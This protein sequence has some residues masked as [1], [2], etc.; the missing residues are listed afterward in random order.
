MTK[1][2]LAVL[3]SLFLILSMVGCGSGNTDSD[4]VVEND[5]EEPIDEEQQKEEDESGEVADAGEVDDSVGTVEE[6]EIGKKKVIKSKKGIELIKESGPFEIKITDIQISTINPSEQYKDMF[7]GKEELSLVV[8]A[9]EVENKSTD[10]NSIYPDQGTI[11]TNTKEQ[12]DA[13]LFFSD[14][15]GGDFIGE[16][17]KSGNV[18]FLLDSNAKDIENIKYVINRGIDEN[19]DGL[20]E[21]IEFEIE[22]E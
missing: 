8:M 16:V 13:H 15:V 7:D 3:L 6:T 10:T 19:F 18:V 21:D 17:V 22:V 2:I 20:G 12:V 4:N 14:S 5:A 9:V 11:I 1:K